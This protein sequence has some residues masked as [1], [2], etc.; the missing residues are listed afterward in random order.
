LTGGKMRIVNRIGTVFR[1]RSMT[2]KK[3]KR[4]KRKRTLREQKKKGY[5][6]PVKGLQRKKETQTKKTPVDD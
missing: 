3:K 6:L 1:G 2:L 5:E 4:R